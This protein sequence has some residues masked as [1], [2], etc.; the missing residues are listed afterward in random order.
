MKRSLLAGLSAL[1][2]LTTAAACGPQLPPPET[3]PTAS[4]RVQ[5]PPA[6]PPSQLRLPLGVPVQMLEEL[7]THAV[8]LPN[9][10]NFE[11]VSAPGT[12]P[13]VDVRYQTRLG[14]VKLQGHG[15]ALEA[16]VEVLYHGELRVRVKTPFGWV[17][18]T[19]GSPWGSRDKP[20]RIEVRVESKLSVTPDWHLKAKSRLSAVKLTAPPV[21]RLCTSGMIKVCVGADEATRRVHAELDAIVRREVGAALAQ[22]D[23]AVAQRA[24]VAQLARQL[25]QRLQTPAQDLVLAPEALAV[26]APAVRDDQLM[27]DVRVRARPRFDASAIATQAP[28][29]APGRMQ[30]ADDGAHFAWPLPWASWSVA[31]SE[32]TRPLKLSPSKLKVQ[33]VD[34]L[35]AAEA[36]DRYWWAVTLADGDRSH[37]LHLSV[38]LRPG[39]E[40]L[41]VVQPELTPA[42]RKRLSALGLD[43]D[44][45]ARSLVKASSLSLNTL[46]AEPL[47]K[48]ER[49]LRRSASPLPVNS[50]R[51]SGLRLDGAYSVDDGLLLQVTTR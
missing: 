1:A 40:R 9:Q 26:A 16:R 50:L 8:A 22:A 2:L 49:Q 17:W 4:A 28:L 45:F 27:L 11:R 13:E 23:R 31:L 18:L 44:G 35:G 47:G 19:K 32:A 10:P 6:L 33:Q 37:V 21:A 30:A 12:S 38:A 5:S 15:D 46:L 24:E 41:S 29:P 25:W 7:L 14:A 34:V 43:A 3:P 42:S 39:G 36:A 20:G 51:D 48:L